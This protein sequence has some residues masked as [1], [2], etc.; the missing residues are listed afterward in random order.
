MSRLQ[1]AG[2]PPPETTQ[3]WGFSGFPTS[4]LHSALAVAG[5]YVLK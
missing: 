2:T 5:F 4:A 1:D 3:F